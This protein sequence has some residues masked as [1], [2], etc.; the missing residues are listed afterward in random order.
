M[1][2]WLGNRQRQGT[3][4]EDV[5]RQ[6]MKIATKMIRVANILTKEALTTGDLNEIENTMKSIRYLAEGKDKE[7]SDEI[8]S[9]AMSV[10]LRTVKIANFG[11]PVADIM[12]FGNGAHVTLPKDL[13]G[14]KIRY[15]VIED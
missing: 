13:I 12:A 6:Q 14:R 4:M 11:I 10:A 7:M 2:S 5:P 3:N 15:T 1:Q 8:S 9:L